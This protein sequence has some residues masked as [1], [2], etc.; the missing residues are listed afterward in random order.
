M[1]IYCRTLLPGAALLALTILQPAVA[2][3]Y[4]PSSELR[5]TAPAAQSETEASAHADDKSRPGPPVIRIGS[6]DLL[7]V[8]VYGVAELTQKSRVSASGEISL[9]LVGSVHIG[10]LTVEEA[11]A[12][13]EK[14]LVE[15]H[16]IKEPNVTV[17]ISEY[18]TQGVS[19]MGEVAKPGTYPVLGSR[20]LLDVLSAAGGLTPKAGKAVTITRRDDPEDPVSVPLSSDLTK[21]SEHNVEILPGDT[22]VVSKAGIIYVVG[23][24]KKPGGFVM[25]NNESLTVLQ[26]VALAEGTKPTAALNRTKLIRRTPSGPQE[27]PIPLKGILSARLPDLPLQPNDIVFVPSSTTRSAATRGLEAILQVATGVA[28]YRK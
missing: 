26:A 16:Y 7:E 15:G 17:F 14:R 2:Q 13:V 3:N 18:A 11:K 24:V 10:G 9:P 20:R 12:L 19:V 28:I 27:V 5:P 21:L 23:D 25:E 4:P 1:F 22:V 6:G 8:S